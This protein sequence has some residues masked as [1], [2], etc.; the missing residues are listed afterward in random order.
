MKK[1]LFV[2]L[3]ML[4][5]VCTVNAQNWY[6]G[7][8]LSLRSYSDA[9]ST[10]NNAERKSFF[11]LAPEIGYNT[12]GRWSFGAEL[13]YSCTSYDGD[14]DS[15]SAFWLKPYA[16]YRFYEDGN[17]TLFAD[18]G[19]LFSTSGSGDNKMNQHQIGVEPGIAYKLTRSFSLVAHVG[20]VGFTGGD[21]KQENGFGLNLSNSISFG[22]YYNF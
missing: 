11:G 9:E 3:L 1:C 13:G 8:S 18:G 7:G 10:H 6:A 4:A 5:G 2:L 12:E 17:L 19:I 14:Y 22:F 16:R 21:N 15:V 20:F